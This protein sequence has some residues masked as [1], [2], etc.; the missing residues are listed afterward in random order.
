MSLFLCLLILLAAMMRPVLGHGYTLISR[1]YK[2]AQGSN[3]ECGS[4]RYEP[5]SLEAPK[6]FPELGPADGQIASA[7]HASFS[8]L[9]AQDPYRWVKTD[10]TAGDF[11][12]SWHFTA[13]HA[14]TGWEYFLTKQ[15][16]DSSTA[17][18]RSSFDLEPFCT[19]QG[20]GSRCEPL[21]LP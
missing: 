1:N 3:Y 15:D 19:I 8:E 4:I 6:G 17:L 2:C 9:D 13:N 20:D 11:A 10:V 21:S 5:Q 7:G 16:W 14:T 12:I 18:S